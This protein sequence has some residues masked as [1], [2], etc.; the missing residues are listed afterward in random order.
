MEMKLFFALISELASFVKLGISLGFKTCWNV[1]IGD[2]IINISGN[3]VNHFA[4][5]K[6]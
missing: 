1:P 3:I 5:R 6:K 2:I 4:L